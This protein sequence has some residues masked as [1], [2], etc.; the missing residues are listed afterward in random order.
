MFAVNYTDGRTAYLTISPYLLRNGDHVA[1]DVI[2][3][4]QE[5]G[6]IPQGE[7]ATVKRVR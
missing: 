5:T 6:E 2:H 4:R 7:I 1:R 3:K